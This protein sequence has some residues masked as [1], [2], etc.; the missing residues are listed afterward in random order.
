[1]RF[2]R[3]IVVVQLR[4]VGP[5]DDRLAGGGIFEWMTQLV[6]SLPAIAKRQPSA[7]AADGR[8]IIT[9]HRAPNTLE[10]LSPTDMTPRLQTKLLKHHTILVTHLLLRPVTVQGAS[11]RLL[12]RT[13][14]ADNIGR[15][16]NLDPAFWM[17]GQSSV[18]RSHVLD[19]PGT[20]P[21]AAEAL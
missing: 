10:N 7:G 9:T 16:K 6:D 15:G 18:N 20:I 4:Y 3:E 2:M 19:K 8:Q 13:G 12:V 14:A 11:G 5:D 21:L 1:M 17:L